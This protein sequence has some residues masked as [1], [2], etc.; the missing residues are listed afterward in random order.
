MP[1]EEEFLR[2]LRRL[3]GDY[4]PKYY[5][6]DGPDHALREVDMWEWAQWMESGDRQVA[7]T[8]NEYKWVS[9]VCLGLDHRHFGKGPPIV[10]ESM[11]FSWDGES[12]WDEDS[13]MPGHPRTQELDCERYSSWDDAETGHKAMVRKY[14]VDQKTRTKVAE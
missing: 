1:E 10:F 4:S 8:G 6:P 14:L 3:M 9:T 11:A 13:L 7:F 2:K 5:I 12:R